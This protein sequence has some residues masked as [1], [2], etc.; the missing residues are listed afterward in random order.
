M[1]DPEKAL[2]RKRRYRERQKVAKHGPQVAGVDLRGKHHNHAKGPDAPR[3][4]NEK[5]IASNGYVKLR[6]GKTHP[7]AD[8]NGYAYEHEIVWASAGLPS[9]GPGDVHHHKNEVKTD[10]RIENIEIKPRPTHGVEHNPTALLDHE[11]VAIRD[12][13]QGGDH[14][15]T[16]AKRYGVPVQYVWKIV[17]GKTRRLA[18]GPAPRECERLQGFPDD[19]TAIPWRG[20][21]P[22]NCPD[23]PR[24]KALGNSMAVPVMRWIGRRIQVAD[25][26]VRG[27]R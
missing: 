17:R 1:R 4:S 8:P 6:V 20:K 25:R 5:M 23:G 18:G 21:P 3:W 15:G 9:P 13:Y 26:F 16:L 11:V 24:Y 27:L 7:L 22:E 2:A 14:T 19:Y 10:N 12:A